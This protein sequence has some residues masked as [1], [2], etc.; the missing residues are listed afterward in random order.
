MPLRSFLFVPG[1]SESKLAGAAT[2]G[3]DAL[4]LDLEDSVA[5]VRKAAAREL[6]ARYLRDP[7]RDRSVRCLARINAIP[8]GLAWDDL[9]A[10]V[11]ARPDGLMLPKGEPQLLAQLDARLNEIEARAGL[12]VGALPVW[13]LATETAHGVFTVGQYAG[14]SARLR[15][16]SWGNEDLATE[17]GAV[18]RTPDGQ[19]AEPFR[20]ARWLCA[21]GAAAAG[22]DAIDGASMDFRDLDAFTRECQDGRRAG[23]VG[24]LAIHPGQVPI[25]NSIFTPAPEEVQRARRIVAAFAEHPELGVIAIDGQV[26]DRPHVRMAERLLARL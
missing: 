13:V 2:R 11:P 1:D 12:Q 22:V 9:D 18:N 10:V 3:A 7:G 23:F 17:L 15:G 4:I 6:V 21:L 26:V 8:T 5:P 16:L 25:I 24:K 19:Y 20:L 14:V